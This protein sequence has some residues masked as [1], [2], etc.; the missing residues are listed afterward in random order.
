LYDRDNELSLANKKDALNETIQRI[1]IGCILTIIM[2]KTRCLSNAQKGQLENF[3]DR[4]YLERPSAEPFEKRTLAEFKRKN[5]NLIGLRK[6]SPF[7]VDEVKKLG[8]SDFLLQLYNESNET[9]GFV[10]MFD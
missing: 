3:I 1:K 5:V 6:I 2:E 4:I 10:R 7:I 8:L 9:F